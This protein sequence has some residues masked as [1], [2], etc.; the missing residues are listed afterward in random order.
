MPGLSLLLD[1]LTNNFESTDRIRI[2]H[3]DP[4]IIR[5][6]STGL[7]QKILQLDPEAQRKL[8]VVGIG[9][10]RSTGDSLGPLTGSKVQE[11]SEGSIAVYGTLDEPVHAGN[12]KD[13]LLTIVEEQPNSLIV[14]VDACLGKSENIGLITL[15]CGSVK[16]GA[17]VNKTLPAIG[18]IYYTG[19][20]N[21]GG[22]ME[23][24]VLQNTRLSMVM[25]MSHKIAMSIVYGC[26][27]AY[28]HCYDH[29]HSF[30][31]AD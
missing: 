17:G 6:L 2:Y 4:K 13:K 25:N 12:L 24:L 5:N 1:K 9:T 23:Y 16:P 31:L 3:Q 18:D 21:I 10:D 19:V 8:V 15:D 11:M 26:Q 28:P 30:A 27:L 22:Y 20:V 14:A 29:I 7:A